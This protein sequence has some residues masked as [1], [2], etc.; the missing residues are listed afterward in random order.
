MNPASDDP[1][2]GEY[3]LKE[4]LEENSITRTWLAE[5]VSVS[6]R[7]LVDEL[8]AEATDHREAFLAEV[9]AK[10]SVDHPLIGSVYEAVAEPGI[11]FYA[12]ELLAGTTLAKRLAEKRTFLPTRISHVLRR[13]SEANIQLEMLGFATSPLNLDSIYLDDQD[14]IR[15]K[16]LTVAGPRDTN[17]S[18]RDIVYL[19]NAI[20]SLVAAD[21]PG[22][23]RVLTLLSWMRGLGVDAPIAWPQ[24]RDL[25]MQI[26]HQLADPLSILTPT[27]AGS[28]VR[29][30]P[31]ASI[32]VATFI[33]IV[34]IIVLA[35]QLRP[36]KVTAPVRTSLPPPILIPAGQYPTPDGLEKE[37]TAYQISAHETT[38]SQYSEFMARLE[39]LATSHNETF[40]DSPDQPE[41]KKSPEPNDWSA[42]LLAAKSNKTWNNLTVSLDT[43]VVGIDWWDAFAYA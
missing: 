14:V 19:G 3:R 32:A 27:R 26:E 22:T 34:T 24:V 4:L 38:I 2:L 11:C 42:L 15:L 10:A 28:I 7:V 40:F 33:A 6:R 21:Q 20:V 35:M 5:Q 37:L 13:V 39:I 17:Q 31:I 29:K 41:S 12:H 43:P 18:S 23:T 30:K 9:R 36:P 25:C 1:H 16:N 8:R